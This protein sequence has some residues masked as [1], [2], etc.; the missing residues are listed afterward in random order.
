M[1]YL[2]KWLVDLRLLNIPKLGDKESFPTMIISLT[3]YGR[4]VSSNVVYY[5]LVSLLRQSIQ[6]SHIVLWLAEDE[7]NEYLL[8][9]KLLSLRAKGV[10][11]CF[12]KDLR[13][14]KKLI[15]SF[16]KFSNKNIMTVDDDIIYSKDTVKLVRENALKY[17]NDILC[18]NSYL[19]LTHNGI[20]QQYDTW[21]ELQKSCR[22]L[23]LFPI[24]YGGTYYPA[25]TLND[26]LLNEGSYLKY[27]P[28][29]DDIWFWFCGMLNNTS[30]TLIK[31]SSIDYSFDA[32][33]Q[34]FHQGAALTHSNVYEHENDKQFLSLFEN[35]GVK[36]NRKGEL[37]F[38][39]S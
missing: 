5:T 19:P 3:S 14:F 10:E 15:P 18:F 8:P 12:C 27:C 28:K 21:K 1:G 24:G 34:Y 11:F 30:K 39:N 33:Y 23:L 32:L 22:D 9:K 31:K 36:I 25:G 16:Q 37:V 26:E 17:P 2:F 38:I 35:Y 6:P 13:S 4:R 29:A 7:W 20:P